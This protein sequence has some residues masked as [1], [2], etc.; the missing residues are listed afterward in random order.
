MPPF[1]V[2]G[3]RTPIGLP[4]RLLV[5]VGRTTGSIVAS[6]N[7]AGGT[8]WFSIG[9]ECMDANDGSSLAVSS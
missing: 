6:E 7:G 9:Q 8:R 3:G 1:K 4:R 5:G 2:F